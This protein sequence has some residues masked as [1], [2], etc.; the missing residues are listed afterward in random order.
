MKPCNAGRGKGLLSEG[1]DERSEVQETDVSLPSSRKL[2]E[3]SAGTA[4][5]S[6]GITRLSFLSLYDKL[7]REEVLSFAY[8]PARENDGKP[9]VDG[10]D[11]DVTYDLLYRDQEGRFLPGYYKH[12][13]FS[14]V[15]QILWRTLAVCA[16]KDR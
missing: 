5:E 16:I 12:Y 6:E 8:W 2:T 1:S 10:E 9:G 13:C 3:T 7:Y 4:C 11:F 14:P 15:I